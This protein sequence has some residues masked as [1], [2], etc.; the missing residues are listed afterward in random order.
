MY[1]VISLIEEY[2]LLQNT[3]DMIEKADSKNQWIRIV[4]PDNKEGCQINFCTDDVVD[5]I[6]E[7]NT[8]RMKEIDEIFKGLKLEQE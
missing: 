4:T 2:K 3:N 5:L 7:Y 6:E 1:K 8:K